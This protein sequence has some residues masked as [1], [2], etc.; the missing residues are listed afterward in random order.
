[1]TMLTKEYENYDPF[2]KSPK[3]HASKYENID[4]KL[5]LT[6]FYFSSFCFKFQSI[7]HVISLCVTI[8]KQ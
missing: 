1:M 8:C 6:F 7:C 5:I 4:F 3:Y 2:Y